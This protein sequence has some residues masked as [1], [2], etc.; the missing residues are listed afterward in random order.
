MP[1]RATGVSDLGVA[2]WAPGCRRRCSVLGTLGRPVLAPVDMGVVV[3]RAAKGLAKALTGF[4]A[5]PAIAC[6]VEVGAAEPP[7]G[8]G[9]D[10]DRANEEPH[11]N[12]SPPRFATVGP[13]PPRWGLRRGPLS[14]AWAKSVPHDRS[15]ADPRT[16]SGHERSVARSFLTARRS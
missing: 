8:Q 3:G 10:D 2:I 7:C 4:D 12:D 11:R 1:R 5:S 9:N 16:D 6:P 13:P 14:P 15:S